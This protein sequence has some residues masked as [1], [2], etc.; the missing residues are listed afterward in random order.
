[1]A[2][3]EEFMGRNQAMQLRAPGAFAVDYR[4]CVTNELPIHTP[5][6][7]LLLIRHL[8]RDEWWGGLVLGEDE[9]GCE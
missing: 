4:S 3:S 1:M 8:V 7:H 2:W 6:H 5:I 9:V